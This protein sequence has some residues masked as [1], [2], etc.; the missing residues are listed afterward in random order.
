MVRHRTVEENDYQF[1]VGTPAVWM[2][3]GAVYGN[4][5]E[6][7]RSLWTAEELR[8]VGC[9]LLEAGE[10]ARFPVI[11]RTQLASCDDPLLPGR[12]TPVDPNVR[13]DTVS[14]QEFPQPIPWFVVASDAGEL[15][16]GSEVRCKGIFGFDD[17]R[18]GESVG[19]A[20]GTSHPLPGRSYSN[21]AL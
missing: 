18:H 15:H 6:R 17:C 20:D 10:P 11:I 2:E 5:F 7:N 3:Q 8:G 1:F 19:L 14:V 4:E 9:E 12:R 21:P 13:L 16:L